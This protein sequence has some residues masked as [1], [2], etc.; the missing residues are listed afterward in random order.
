VV[1][2]DVNI[3]GGSVHNIQENAKQLVVANKEIGLEINAHK[4]KYMVMCRYQNI[5]RSHSMNIDNSSFVSVQEIK[6]L[7]TTLINGNSILEEIKSRLK[8]G[9]DC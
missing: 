8:S 9:N 3:L 2:V 1:N 5:G 6:Y 7:E 4:T